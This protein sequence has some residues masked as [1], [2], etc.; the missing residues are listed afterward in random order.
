ML[1]KPSEQVLS[2]LASLQGEPRFEA[3]R[4]WL[5]QSLQNLYRESTQT[6]EEVL[7]R[8]K[9]GAAQAVED[10]LDKASNAQDALRRRS[11]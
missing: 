6:R 11:R 2:A 3:I 1:Q 8:W 5:E 9:Q 7:S 4:Q 10:F